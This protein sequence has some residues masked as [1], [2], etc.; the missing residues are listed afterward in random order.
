MVHTLYREVLLARSSGCDG[1]ELLS[2]HDETDSRGGTKAP[3]A[4]RALLEAG[5]GLKPPTPG[6]TDPGLVL[7]RAAVPRS[8]HGS[9]RVRALQPLLQRASAVVQL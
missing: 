4:H 7:R 5:R 9:G 8:H 2:A 6:G 3:S 1:L